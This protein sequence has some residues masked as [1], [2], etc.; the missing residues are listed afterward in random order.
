MIWKEPALQVG[1]RGGYRVC[2]ATN[3]KLYA[4]IT[5]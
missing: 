2:L 4:E 1:S 3:A 5:R